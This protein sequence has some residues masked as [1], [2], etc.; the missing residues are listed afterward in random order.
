[1]A[2]EEEE[3]SSSISTLCVSL[4]LIGR[5]MRVVEVGCAAEAAEAHVTV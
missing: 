4:R 2:V 5:K 1:M 3:D